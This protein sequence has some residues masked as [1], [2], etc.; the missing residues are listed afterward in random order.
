MLLT[1]LPYVAATLLTLL[2]YIAAT[3]V[4]SLTAH[5]LFTGAEGEL[6]GDAPWRLTVPV[7]IGGGLTPLAVAQTITSEQLPLVLSPAAFAFAFVLATLWMVRDRRRFLR[8]VHHLH[9][10]AREF[11]NVRRGDLIIAAG[12]GVIAYGALVNM[13]VA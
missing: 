2:P 11:G 1:L 3:L 4:Y 7:V 5:E 8:L 6:P 10:G 9:V 12:V 13:L